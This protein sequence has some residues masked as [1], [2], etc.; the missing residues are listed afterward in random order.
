MLGLFLVLFIAMVVGV[1]AALGQGLLISINLSLP[2]YCLFW[3]ILQR[4]TKRYLT[5]IA[6]NWCKHSA[7]LSNVAVVLLASCMA[8]VMYSPH[9][10]S[11]S[12]LARELQ[13]N[14]YR[15]T[16]WNLPFA[17]GYMLLGIGLALVSNI[18]GAL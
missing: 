11:V 1:Q 2:F 9:N 15:I 5:L 4:K 6:G 17:A 14:P 18:F 10:L 3:S 7:S 8:T 16:A 13:I 12:L